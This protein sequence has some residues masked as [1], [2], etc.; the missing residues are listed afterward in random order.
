MPL[1]FSNKMMVGSSLPPIACRRAHVSYMLFVVVA[2]SVVHVLAV[3]MS[4]MA[5]VL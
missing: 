5:G 4:S 3:Y 2:Y 1:R